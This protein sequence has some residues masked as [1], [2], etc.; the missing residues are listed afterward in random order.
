MLRPLVVVA[1]ATLVVSTSRAPRAQP[2]RPGNAPADT[3]LPGPI[4][5]LT[6]PVLDIAEI[7]MLRVEHLG[8]PGR[9]PL[10]FIPAL[11][12]GPWQWYREIDGLA[13]RY[14]IYALTL[15]G[16]DGRPL[17]STN[18]LM[19]RATEDV[20]QLIRDRNLPDPI[21]IGH[22]L[23]AAL[24]VLVAESYPMNLGAVIPVEGGFP[25][26]PTAAE[27][28]QRAEVSAAPYENATPATLEGVLR[29]Q[30][31]RYTITAPSDVAAVA[32]YAARSSP[33]AI[34]VWM[35]AA[36]ALDLTDGLKTVRA[37]L[38]EIVP[39]DSL[40]DPY[41]GFPTLSDK[42]HAYAAWVANTP[43][44]T[45]EMIDHSRH[46]VMIDQPAEFD[47]VLFDAIRRFDRGASTTRSP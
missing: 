3:E 14:D 8:Q 20:S 41:Q 6:T 18:D 33:K 35:R 32:H 4:A 24:A 45:V 27:R 31:L 23:G 47:R 30:T 2:L 26:A 43:H 11:F 42:A 1:V 28:A 10:I 5:A 25:I 12:C 19:R 7:G 13:S 39:F 37:P 22:S 29:A 34:A 21:I 36:L 46:F 40:I 17:T 44:G 15:P 16:F 38:L 9:R